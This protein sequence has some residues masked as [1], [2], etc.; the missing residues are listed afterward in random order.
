MLSLTSLTR[1]ERNQIQL[2]ELAKR[3]TRCRRCSLCQARHHVVFGAGGSDP[4]VMLIAAHPNGWE[5]RAGWPMVE[6]GGRILG[7]S[8]HRIGL[9]PIRDAYATIIVKCVPPKGAEGRRRD[10]DREEAAL[11]R[12]LLDRQIEIL[13]PPII[14]L[15]GR[16]ANEMFLADSRPLALYA[17]HI[18]MMGDRRIIVSQHNPYG[19][20]FDGKW[21]KQQ[22]FNAIWTEVAY[23]IEGLGRLWKPDAPL[24]RS[25]WQYDWGMPACSR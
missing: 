4:V 9:S 7:E 14:V 18:R 23:R 24:F 16:A 11:C 20:V 5:D 25:G 21:Q 17:G 6:E 19:L 1:Q 3:W 22:E 10:V 13:N 12:P 8:L 2:E 15:L